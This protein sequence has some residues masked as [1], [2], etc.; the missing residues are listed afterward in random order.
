MIHEI[1]ARC[2]ERIL[3]L[4]LHGNN[5]ERNFQL[6]PLCL[7]PVLFAHGFCDPFLV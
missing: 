5:N 1:N 2:R 6:I 7:F 3:S 4:S